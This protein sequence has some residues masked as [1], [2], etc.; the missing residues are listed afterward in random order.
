MCYKSPWGR[1]REKRRPSTLAGGPWRRPVD[2]K[3]G[4]N[5][6]RAPHDQGSDRPTTKDCSLRLQRTTT[7]YFSTISARSDCIRDRGVFAERV[8]PTGSRALQRGLL[9]QLIVNPLLFCIR[10]RRYCK[11]H[12]LYFFP[13]P[14]VHGSLRPTLRCWGNTRLSSW[15]R[16]ASDDANQLVGTI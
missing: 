6:P 12:F 8:L 13:L 2:I 10:F 1:G 14:H 7:Y 15:I 9:M 16:S 11:Q 3:P 5:C 4:R